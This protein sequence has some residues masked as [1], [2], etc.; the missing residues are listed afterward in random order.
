AAPGCPEVEVNDL[1]AQLL[2]CQ[3]GRL[4]RRQFKEGRR[5]ADLYPRLRARRAQGQYGG[6]GGRR[7]RPV[8]SH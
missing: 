8:R 1:A 7:P 3:V 2:Q 4:F 6:N 5:L